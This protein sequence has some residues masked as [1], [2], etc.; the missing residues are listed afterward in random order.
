MFIRKAHSISILTELYKN[1][2]NEI[3]YP[4]VLSVRT[5]TKI[6]STTFN[7]LWEFSRKNFFTI[8]YELSTY[9]RNES[10]YI[11]HIVLEIIRLK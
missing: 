7:S 4:S 6:K 3:F 1:I 5:I 2:F 11:C 10:F 8:S 9:T